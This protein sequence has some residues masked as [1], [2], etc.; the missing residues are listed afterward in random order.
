MTMKKIVFSCLLVALLAVL[1]ARWYFGGSD[2]GRDASQNLTVAV[3]AVP[4]PE[5]V[6]EEPQT[7]AVPTAELVSVQAQAEQKDVFALYESI[8]QAYRRYLAGEKTVPLLENTSL[9]TDNAQYCNEAGLSILYSYGGGL[10]YCL[11]DLDQDGIEELIIGSNDSPYYQDHLY[12]VFSLID[13]VP[14]R[15]FVSS[16]R[17]RLRLCDNGLLFFE[18]SGGAAYNSRFL[19]RFTGRSFEFVEGANMEDGICSYLVG[20]TGD[21]SYQSAVS[22]PMTMEEYSAYGEKLN[23]SVVRLT[24]TAF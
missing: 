22:T 13:G 2:F 11:K 19:Y 16:E 5:S 8:L 10:G 14:Q 7:A 6:V 3:E 21:E 1:F 4:S 9:F 17:I 18:G 24:Y 15:I 23:S 12:D 20:N